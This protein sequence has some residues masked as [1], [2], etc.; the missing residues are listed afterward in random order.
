MRVAAIRVAVGAVLLLCVSSAMARG[1]IGPDLREILLSSAADELIPVQVVMREQADPVR[2]SNLVRNLDHKAK[3]RAVVSEL[4]VFSEERQRDILDYLEFAVL[5]GEADRV[6]PFWVVNAVHAE[7]TPEVIE[8]LARM[9][10]VWYVESDLL[11]GDPFPTFPSDLPVPDPDTAWGVLKINAPDVWLE[12]YT[13]ADVVVGLIDTGVNWHHVDLADHLWTDANYPNHGWDFLDNDN[14]PMDTSGHGTHCAGSIAGDGTAG[15][16]TGVAPDAQIMGCRVRTVADSIAESQVWAA[17]EFVVS[18]PLS[19]DNGG[20]LISMSLGWRYAWDPRRATWR[21][22]CTNVGLAGVPMIVAAGNERGW[23]PPPNDLRCPG[24]VPPPWQNPDQIAGGLSAVI[25]IG[26]TTIADNYASFSSQGPVAWNIDPFFDY[27]YPPGLLKPDVCAPGDSVKSLAYNN[28]TGYLDGWSGTSMATPHVAGTVALMLQKNNLLSPAEVDEILETTALDLGPPGKDNDYGAGRIRAY[29]AVDA[30][31]PPDR[32]NVRY[33][34]I[35]YDDS[36]GGNGDGVFD[37]WETV[38]AYVTLDNNGGDV[39]ESVFVVL[40]TSDTLLVIEDSTANYPDIGMGGSARND[41]D[42]FVFSADPLTPEGH[43]ADV[44]AHIT[45][46]GGYE[47]DR[48]FQVQIGISPTLWADHNIGNMVFTVTC[49]GACGHTESDSLSGEGNGLVFPKSGGKKLL[50]IGSFWAGNANGYVVNRDYTDDRADWQTVVP[51]GWMR[52]G[53]TLFSDQDGLGSYDDGG[54]PT[55]KGLVV[56]QNSWAWADPPYNDF[57]IMTYKMKNTG[58][59]SL[60]G[61][62]A[63]QFMDFDVDLASA[64]D[65]RGGREVDRHMIFMH[66]TS[67]T[68]HVAVKALTGPVKNLTFIDNVLYRDPWGYV[69]DS[70]KWEMLSGVMGIPQASFDNDWGVLASV[71]PYD[72]PAGDSLTVAFAIVGGEDY[73]DLIQNSDWADSIFGQTG[74]LE[75]TAIRTSARPAL[76]YQNAPNPFAFATSIRFSTSGTGDLAL[77]VLDTSGRVVATLR[78]GRTVAGIHSVTWNGKSDKGESL[79]SGVYFYRLSTSETET[80]RKMVLLR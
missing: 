23:D 55:P 68:Q 79:P 41:T 60:R 58:S 19:P 27:L 63:G 44:N 9:A 7:A 78:E 26:A 56:Q 47:W 37:P 59:S 71:G 25:S 18:P 8:N 54:A 14:D 31:W 64:D 40:S 38:D 30:T 34:R 36:V 70:Y 22:S 1:V 10:G 11:K 4:R 16:N 20:H 80:T 72:L 12:G 62:Y 43:V 66:D 13:G 48:R 3:R 39:A 69:P 67:Y 35:A 74:I 57:V 24:D 29:M 46:A 52:L 65:D 33:K 76:L 15:C 50:R 51:G 77:R 45:V 17:M 61:L 53:A 5:R 73:A 21:T 28:N 75:E 49:I 32:P 6:T 2:M 42:P